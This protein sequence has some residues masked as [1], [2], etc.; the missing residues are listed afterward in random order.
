M[1]VEIISEL[2]S[3]YCF[4]YE[5]DAVITVGTVISIAQLRIL[6]LVVRCVRA[7]KLPYVERHSSC[8][9]CL[10]VSMLNVG[11]VIDLQ[12]LSWLTR[13]FLLQYI[14][15]HAHTCTANNVFYSLII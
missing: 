15:S 4:P 14:I 5:K 9:N 13:L 1:T 11:L 8:I 10:V 7:D 3:L 6:I 12:Y 2:V